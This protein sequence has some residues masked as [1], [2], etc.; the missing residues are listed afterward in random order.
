MASRS[1]F[2]QQLDL[3]SLGQPAAPPRPMG[4]AE[5]LAG[6]G[7]PTTAAPPR[8]ASAFT[9]TPEQ[10]Q[11]WQ[12]ARPVEREDPFDFGGPLGDILRVID[13]PRAFVAST[14]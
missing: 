3:P 6:L 12:G 2:L 14:V 4:R 10:L 13:Y 8:P 7:Q 1:E 9:F 5:L 11:G